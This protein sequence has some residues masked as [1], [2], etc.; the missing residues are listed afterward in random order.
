MLWG[1]NVTVKLALCP[2]GIVIGNVRPLTVNSELLRSTDD[3]VTFVPL[4]SKLPPS[5]E[6]DPTVTLPK[7]SEVGVTESWLF[8]VPVP[9]RGISRLESE[10]FEIREMV[11]LALPAV[12]G[13]KAAEKVKLCPEAIT[14]GIVRP[15][16][17]K[18]VPF[19]VACET[20]SVALPV[21]VRVS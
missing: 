4:A 20:V 9:V 5:W 15:L 2:A 17:L 12:V 6:C 1:V 18:P 13:A 10:A 7:L 21:L 8:A 19:A 11:P 3:T 16:I 14:R